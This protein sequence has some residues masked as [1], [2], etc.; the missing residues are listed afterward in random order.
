MKKFFGRL[1]FNLSNVALISFG[2]YLLLRPGWPV[3][4]ALGL[5]VGL[6]AWRDYLARESHVAEKKDEKRIADLE[7]RVSNLE[8]RNLIR[9]R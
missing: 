5:A 8:A 3:L 2:T 1:N 9:S 4:A 6:T 7:A